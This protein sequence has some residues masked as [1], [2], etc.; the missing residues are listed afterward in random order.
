MSDSKSLKIAIILIS[1][2]I[3]GYS[4]YAAEINIQD[5]IK[6]YWELGLNIPEKEP[7]GRVQTLNKKGAISPVLDQAT[8]D[9][10]DFGKNKKVLEIGGGYGFVM[11]KM[12]EKYPNTIYHINDL[13]E[14]HLFIAA[15]NI[16]LLNISH[17]NLENI[18]FITGDIAKMDI[19]DKYDAI[20]VARVLHYVSPEK[21]K[22]STTQFFNLLKP[23]GRIYIIAITPYVKR[24]EKFIKE[25]EDR[26]AR[27]IPYPGYVNSLRDW[28]NT[29]V[30]SSSQN[31]AIADEA[32][33]FLDEKVLTQIFSSNGFKV[34]ECKMTDL[35]YKWTHGV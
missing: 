1:L 9:F 13:D 32:F 15:H 18:K 19:K 6:R 23:G 12:L 7:D 25:Y 10:M 16:S 26:L 24:Y 4:P 20:L 8:L 28:L 27:G 30:T 17:K 29:E 34:I 22:Q 11:G 31:A 5:A 2:F 14:R 21:L 35:G 33:M 3:L